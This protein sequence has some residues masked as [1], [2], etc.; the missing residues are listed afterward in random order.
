MMELIDRAAALEALG[1]KPFNWND[2]PEEQAA[3]REYNSAYNAIACLPAVE[4]VPLDKLCEMLAE[5]Y[6]CPSSGYP[7]SGHACHPDCTDEMFATICG[8]D[9]DH[10]SDAER[11]KAFLVHWMEGLD[12]AG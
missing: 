1:E 6:H 9:C 10:Y 12:A 7:S 4:A 2:T 11:W 8:T 5:M 3:I